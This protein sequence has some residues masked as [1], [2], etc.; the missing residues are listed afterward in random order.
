MEVAI[1]K[2]PLEDYELMFELNHEYSHWLL[3]EQYFETEEILKIERSLG[4]AK[5]LVKDLNKELFELKFP[6]K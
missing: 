6:K 4:V 5:Q 3:K 1:I 2:M